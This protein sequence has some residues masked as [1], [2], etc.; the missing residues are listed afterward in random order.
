MSVR[1]LAKYQSVLT[2][3]DLVDTSQ[4]CTGGAWHLLKAYT[5]PASTAVR[6]GVG[7]P[8]GQKDALGRLYADIKDAGGSEPGLIKLE[9]VDSNDNFVAKL[10]EGRTDLTKLGSTDPAL[11]Q[12]FPAVGNWIPEGYK[13]QLW[14]KADATATITL[15][16]SLV[17]IS[18][19][20][21]TYKV[22]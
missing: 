21:G 16:D 4:A 1:I 13:I 22:S 15:A 19:L 2:Q 20:K 8:M 12:V 7:A 11:R 9:V 5:V 18:C 3:A 14:Y 6:L 10:F 17:Q